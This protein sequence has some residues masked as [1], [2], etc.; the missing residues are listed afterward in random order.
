MLT[1]HDISS[2]NDESLFTNADRSF[3]SRNFQEKDDD[4]SLCTKQTTLSQEFSRM[5]RKDHL[6]APVNSHQG[7]NVSN[8]PV[9]P[10]RP[11]QQQTIS[12]ITPHTNNFSSILSNPSSSSSKS[13]MQLSVSDTTSQS[14]P[15][16]PKSH[17][18]PWIRR[19]RDRRQIEEAKIQLHEGYRP[20]ISLE[21]R[22]I[23]M[24]LG[25]SSRSEEPNLL[26][27]EELP[28]P[29]KSTTLTIDPVDFYH[30]EDNSFRIHH[31]IDS[32]EK[33]FW[34]KEL[35]AP[36]SAVTIDPVDVDHGD[37]NSF[38]INY[39][40]DSDG[41]IPLNLGDQ[42]GSL[43]DSVDERLGSKLIFEDRNLMRAGSPGALRLTQ[44]GIEVHQH[45]L[46]QEQARNSLEENQSN[47]FESWR[48]R[49]QYRLYMRKLIEERHERLTMH[50]SHGMRT[51]SN[52]LDDTDSSTRIR[53]PKLKVKKIKTRK[54]PPTKMTTLQILGLASCSEKNKRKS[55]KN[56]IATMSL[57]PMDTLDDKD[58]Q[59][60]SPR[61]KNLPF[62]TIKAQKVTKELLLAKER[63]KQ[64]EAER[65]MDES[66]LQELI[67]IAQMR[68]AY[69]EKQRALEAKPRL[70]N[71]LDSLTVPQNS[72]ILLTKSMNCIECAD[73]S[74]SP[75]VSVIESEVSTVSTA[76]SS[77]S[78]VICGVNRMTH[79][80]LP[81][82]HYSFCEECVVRMGNNGV[83][84]CPICNEHD[85]AF[86]RVFF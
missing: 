8:E 54:P 70:T 3:F 29:S 84:A 61:K 36:S 2:I 85:A 45:K 67:R 50:V 42:E 27:E 78:C 39:S 21:K 51:D 82:M 13:T 58:L 23:Q 83:T 74:T 72:V 62:I 22:M 66:E 14:T 6:A 25:S 12:Q 32:D 40:I 73:G 65:E 80:A 17:V 68:S 30:G 81:C 9:S 1:N 11:K 60:P 69:L 19:R 31:S 56:N 79:G 47:G 77:P 24:R 20:S 4:M 64:M 75:G 26:W 55:K 5:R 43:T 52:F 15:E 7:I 59:C 41:E 76:V 37:D 46:F 38:P 18:K 34:E 10:S 63:Q 33:P 48:D 28:E 49:Q 16:V 35:P 71:K 86:V 53:V 44:S 57:A